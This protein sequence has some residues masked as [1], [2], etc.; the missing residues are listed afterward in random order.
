MIKSS[1]AL[2]DVSLTHGQAAKAINIY[3]KTRFVLSEPGSDAAR[4]IHPPID[5]ILLINIGK[6]IEQLRPLVRKPGSREPIS[7]RALDSE[8][9]E[10]LIDGLRKHVGAEPFWKLEF[11]WDVGV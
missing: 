7:W 4:V 1:K 9:Y 2:D 5:R 10:A 11:F 3:L 6:A 8:E